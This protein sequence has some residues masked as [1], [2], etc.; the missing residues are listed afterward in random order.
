MSDW[1]YLYGVRAS[2]NKLVPRGKVLVMKADRVVLVHPKDMV[3]FQYPRAAD[4][5]APMMELV[6][7][8]ARSKFGAASDR[9]YE[10]GREDRLTLVNAD[11]VREVQ[12][13]NIRFNSAVRMMR[14]WR[15]ARAKRNG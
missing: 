3:T 1:P 9:L 7:C 14:A 2:K 8:E 15:R 5:L 11:Q 10:S 12:L 4:R 6:L 13:G